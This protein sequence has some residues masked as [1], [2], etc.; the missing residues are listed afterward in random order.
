MESF[1]FIIIETLVGGPPAYCFS[2]AGFFSQLKGSVW[3]SVPALPSLIL[4][5]VLLIHN[6]AAIFRCKEPATG[7]C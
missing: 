3:L 5:I 4:G 7:R 6:S 2:A 1:G